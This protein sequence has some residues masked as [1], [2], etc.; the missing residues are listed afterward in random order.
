MRGDVLWS[1]YPTLVP[2]LSMSRA[3]G[4]MVQEV[5]SLLTISMS[6]AEGSMV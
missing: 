6:R 4:S 2:T 1:R 5:S 3:E